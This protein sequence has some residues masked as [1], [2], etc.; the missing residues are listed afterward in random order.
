[1]CV[2]MCRYISI[3]IYIYIHTYIVTHICIMHMCPN[4]Y[5]LQAHTAIFQAHKPTRSHKRSKHTTLMRI[6]PHIHTHTNGHAHHK[7][8]S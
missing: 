7:K 5:I 6:T 4:T 1:M 8:S 2:Y 3:Y